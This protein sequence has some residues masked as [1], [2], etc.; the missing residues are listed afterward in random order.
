MLQRVAA[1][2]TS[3]RGGRFAIVAS[4]YNGRY[5]NSMLRA[6]RRVLK[7]AGAA[8]VRV[9][10]VPGA[11]E[12]PVV[13][14]ALAR[15]QP[16]YAAVICL[17]LILRGETVH[18]QQIG[19]TVSRLLG[20]IAVQTGVPVI[21]EVLLLENTAQADKRCLAPEHNRGAEAAHTAVAMARVMASLR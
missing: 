6:A 4:E 11:F 8:Q 18:A 13:A 3:A 17:G 10:R 5:V 12:I 7:E 16:P 15:Q 14:A 1:T 20:D 19:D 2:Q 9:V 21:H